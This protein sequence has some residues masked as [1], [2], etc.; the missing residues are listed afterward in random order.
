MKKL[1]GLLIAFIVTF[2]LLLNFAGLHPNQSLAAMPYTTNTDTL[3]RFEFSKQTGYELTECADGTMLLV[4]QGD[5]KA[6][7]QVLRFNPANKHFTKLFSFTGSN[8]S[9][10]G[11]KLATLTNPEIFFGTTRNGG[12]ANKGV[13]YSVDITTGKQEIVYSFP[14]VSGVQN[15]VIGLQRVDD[16]TLLGVGQVKNNFQLFT[17]DANTKKVNVHSI[18]DDKCTYSVKSLPIMIRP[19]DY[20]VLCEI[21]SQAKRHST[22]LAFV[23]YNLLSNQVI[24]VTRET[25]GLRPASDLVP[26]KD[27]CIYVSNYFSLMADD[28]KADFLFVKYDPVAHN[29]S[30]RQPLLNEFTVWGPPLAADRQGNLIGAFLYG[31]EANGGY[32]IRYD[33]VKDE[34]KTVH[35]WASGSPGPMT[36]DAPLLHHSNGNYYGFSFAGGSDFE[37]RFF[38]LNP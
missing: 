37:G 32:I 16:H 31:G 7:A 17:F 34:M 22:D 8:G 29:I 12:K 10:P 20:V 18:S 27:G 11:M 1:T 13:I 4:A 35:E 33:P 21:K 26:G 38:S 24:S 6:K 9:N 36:S 30:T 3:Y 23:E 19:G 2:T 5:E 28:P 15:P 14:L 25:F